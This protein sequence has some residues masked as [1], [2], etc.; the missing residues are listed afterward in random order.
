M[1]D[2]L[3]GE[4]MKENVIVND[5]ALVNV[6]FDMEETIL[7]FMFQFFNNMLMLGKQADNDVSNHMYD[8]VYELNQVSNTLLF[9]VI[10]QLEFKLKV[11]FIKLLKLKV[12]K[13]NLL[14]CIRISYFLSR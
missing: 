14:H 9:G 11:R 7:N 2:Q 3:M 1:K 10:P 8:L 4:K 13:I 6:I 5:K 12:L